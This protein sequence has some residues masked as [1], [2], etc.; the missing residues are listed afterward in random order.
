MLS[1]AIGN[2]IAEHFLYKEKNLLILFLVGIGL[3]FSLFECM[4]LILTFLHGS[5]TLLILLWT[6]I[7]LILAVGGV[8][9]SGKNFWELYRQRV[10]SFRF[11]YILFMFLSCFCFR[12]FMSHDIRIQMRM[13][14]LMLE[15][16]RLRILQIR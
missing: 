14:P 1:I 3:N 4:A 6:G 5:L 10:K 2:F 7:T 9:K 16:R 12:F 15:R 11:N 8:Y 13:M